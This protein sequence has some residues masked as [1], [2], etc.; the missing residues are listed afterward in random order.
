MFWDGSRWVE[1]TTPKPLGS[2][3]PSRR[4]ATDLVTTGIMAVFLV[5]LLIPITGVSAATPIAQLIDRWS[6]EQAVRTYSERSSAVKYTGR[7]ERRHNTGYRGDYANAT[8]QKG[9]TATFT[10]TGSA[11]AWAGPVGPTR[12][13]AKVY[14]DGVLQRTVDTFGASFHA[15]NVLYQRTFTSSGKH[16][17][18]IVAEGT[19][20]RST[21]AVDGFIIKA[22]ATTPTTSGLA[23]AKQ[24]DG[25]NGKNRRTPS[26][27][28][29]TPQ[30]QSTPV[31]PTP[32]G[33]TP[34][35][36]TGPTI[37]DVT[38]TNV[39]DTSAII[40][41]T[42]SEVATGQVEYGT[43]GAYGTRSTLESSFNYS[44]HIQQL[45]GL[46]GGTTYHYR[47]RSTT[48]SGVEVISVDRVFTTLGVIKPVITPSP[49][50][51]PT[52]VPTAAPT[53]RPTPTPT[54]PPPPPPV[55]SG[56]LYGSGV[57]IDSKNNYQVGW[58]GNQRVS[59]RFRAGTTSTLISVA[60]NQRGGPGYSGGNGGGM[61]LEV[62]T[63]NG[64]QPSG[65]V[66]A[67][68]SFR[69][70]NPAG[71]WENQQAYAFASPPTLTKG[72]M[73][74]IVMT[75][76]DPSPTTNYVSANEIFTYNTTTPRQPAFSDDYAVLRNSGAGWKV[77]ANDTPVMDL[78]YG[79]G[80]HDGNAYFGIVVDYMTPISGSAMTRERFT[81]S[82]SDR[83]VSS[84]GVR[85][86]RI[87]GSSPLT[88]RLESS[89]GTVL[90]TGTASATDIPLSGSSDLAGGRWVTVSFGGSVTL[91]AGSTYSLRLS[92]T[93]DTSFEA[94]PIREQ[95]ASS[96]IWGSRAFRDGKAQRT[97]TG[98]WADVYA[99]GALD[100]Q[101]Y[102]R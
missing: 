8:D 5:G 32:A 76:T 60:I 28:P 65:T 90:A 74:H 80:Y 22:D 94:V 25:G 38:A 89:S 95:E 84:A 40:S 31:A 85:V 53:P 21:V 81:V 43:T 82:G 29:T 7:W 30:A 98:T 47:V 97:T 51:V 1:E 27:Q 12:G 86:K 57:G 55:T 62:Q 17:L 18:R 70:G 33:P 11:V 42:V 58:T 49:T 91:Q 9:A 26:P 78:V 101:F 2:P 71:T 13:K 14:L 66:L 87:S 23:I 64:G 4:R 63:D 92:T 45:N 75:S 35:A 59:H 67:S 36:L 88:V 68:V 15:N 50:P 79:N 96:P 69:S 72:T 102:L 77:M 61:R 10:F 6:T 20:R 56:A 3:P 93:S 48:A 52:A 83:T 73:Y 99:Y 24:A 41:W 19:A 54:S 44:H 34:A 16:T 37:T 46:T 100:W 39:T